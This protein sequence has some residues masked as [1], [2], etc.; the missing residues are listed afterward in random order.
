MPGKAKISREDM[1][2][3]AFNIVRRGGWSQLTARNLAKELKSSTMPIYTQFKTME[4][5]EEG[6][7]QKA[8]EL[9]TQYESRPNTTVSALN[10]GIGY[11]LFAWEEP[12]LFAAINDQKHVRLQFKYGDPTFDLQVKELSRNPRMQG[13]SDQQ[14]RDFQFLAW[15]FVHGI[16]SMKNW[17][18]ETYGDVTE[19]K[20][21]VFIRDGCRTLTKGFI[22]DQTRP[23]SRKS[24]K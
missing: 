19:E 6:V 23:V 20:L 16:A 7:V 5:L 12:N 3:G 1:I 8:M 22:Q 9:L 4:D 21:M 2:K 14:L 15:I 24:K 13:L 17:V 18:K 11:V 10:H